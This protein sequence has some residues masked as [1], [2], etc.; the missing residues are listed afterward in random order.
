[1][2]NRLTL[3]NRIFLISSLLV[4]LAFVLIWIFVR[5]Q[6]KE[7]IIKERTTIVSQL[8]EY[9]L[10]RSDQILRNWLN[11]TNYLAEQII[12]SPAEIENLT[13]KTINLTPG[14]MRIALADP[15][16][17]ET[18]DIKKTMYNQ[19]NFDLPELNWQASRVDPR[20]SISWT[21]DS[22]ATDFFLTRRLIQLGEEVLSLTL[23]FDSASLTRDLVQIPLG[24][25]YVANIVDSEGANLVPG[26]PL[27][28]PASL[29]GDAS[30]SD[31]TT[32]RLGNND[33]FIMTSRFESVPYWHVIIVEDSFILQ[34]VRDLILF[35]AIS[36]AAILLFMFI[37][38]WYVSDRINKPVER[39]I[40]DVEYMSDLDFSHS[41]QAVSLPEFEVMQETLEHI[42]ITLHRYQKINV[43]RIILEE[44]KNRYMMT[45][46][47]DLI[48]I[49]D[50]NRHFG[51]VNNQ[52]REFLEILELNPASCTLGDLTGH[53]DIRI[54]KTNQVTH[55]PEPFTVKI[56]QAECVLKRADRNS[57]Y[58]YQYLSILDENEVEQAAMVLF[59]DKTEDRLLD[60]K[61]NDMINIIVHE[62]KNPITAVVGLA[63]LLLNVKDMAGEEREVLIKEIYQSG[64]RMNA[65][66]NRFL[67]V[68]K[69]E[70][71]QNK[72]E[73]EKV[74][75]AGVVEEIKSINHA[76]L[77]EKD[78]E[79]KVSSMGDQF[80][81]E[82]NRELLFDA[83]QNI[84]SNAIKY[85]DSG[86]T[87]EIDLNETESHVHIAVTDFGYGISME[88]Q[89]KI[90]DKFFRV[91]S[92]AKAARQKG[93][94]LGLAYVKEI[95]HLH[96]GDIN[97]ESNPDIGCRF[98]LSFPK[99]QE[100][101]HEPV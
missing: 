90:Y 94:G 59:H 32:I 49:L 57:Y 72:I 62:L 9:S 78:L 79:V 67:E 99:N 61:R 77:Q 95:I 12:D 51:F 56:E 83:V 69:I 8:Q 55:Y 45:Y 27:Q 71:G 46:S 2:I 1:M 68:Q 24:G 66:V 19:L 93:T 39:I 52:F 36:G 30:Y 5:P 43:E 73:T 29:I 96:K 100:F 38:S 85:G 76:H 21:A 4:F 98:I 82:A 53:S 18:L 33:W 17:G 89:K 26:Q 22:S 42:R 75:V 37:F 47:E 3:R 7:A 6:Y 88:D 28:F 97:L 15:V 10:Q 41:V 34:P 40:R 50:A 81:V 87:I 63:K 60:I 11:A 101:I 14:L 23:Y 80:E 35:S 84:L 58:D 44:W 31:E 13:S 65:L 20:I 25:K 64:E 70:A 74:N 54:G 16:S 91:R 92:N 86:R 48:G